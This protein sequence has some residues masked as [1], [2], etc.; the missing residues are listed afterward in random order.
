[1]LRDSGD[2][3]V[4]RKPPDNPILHRL[5]S[6]C[7]R[8]SDTAEP[9]RH[10]ASQVG[11]ASVKSRK[12]RRR[13]AGQ[14]PRNPDTRRTRRDRTARRNVVGLQLRPEEKQAPARAGTLPRR[15]HRGSP[16][17]ALRRQS[18]A[19]RERPAVSPRQRAGRDQA[20]QSAPRRDAAHDRARR[21]RHA[22]QRRSRLAYKSGDLPKDQKVYAGLVKPREMEHDS[23]IYRAYRKEA[24]THRAQRRH[25][26]PRAARLRDQGR[27]AEGHLRRAQS[28]PEARHG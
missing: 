13:R 12:P 4:T 22:D 2:R 7:E 5:K 28:R 1:M 18:R 11:T 21:S 14:S 23:Q 20:R 8:A 27:R 25:Q 19:A 6:L 3:N 10:A 17:D 15:P 9:D 26:P 24:E 16:R